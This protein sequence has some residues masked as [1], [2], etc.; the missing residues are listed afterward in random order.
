MSGE[1]KDSG[2][3]TIMQPFERNKANR[4][5]KM[6]KPGKTALSPKRMAPP[7]TGNVLKRGHFGGGF[8]T[9]A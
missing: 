1:R 8:L 4:E 2:C 6:R 9:N 3:W 7:T 5:K